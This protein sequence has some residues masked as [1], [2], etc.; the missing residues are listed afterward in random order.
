MPYSPPEFFTM[1]GTAE[2]RIP[3]VRPGSQGIFMAIWLAVWTLGGALAISGFISSVLA[4]QMQASL[5]LWLLGWAAGEAVVGVQLLW[6][7]RG[8]ELVTLTGGELRVRQQA[9]P[10]HRE[11][12][13]DASQVRHLR[14]QD[15]EWYERRKPERRW[16]LEGGAVAFDYGSRTVQFGI[17]LNDYEGERI[18][19][20]L[21]K[22][23]IAPARPAQ[24]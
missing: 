4:H 11:K 1:A 22:H 21:H 8:L 13:Y 18:V 12:T 2:I 7:Y 9:G 23:G 19:A 20:F 10:L 24:A 14:A 5:G 15:D 16:P 3:A 6:F 17:G